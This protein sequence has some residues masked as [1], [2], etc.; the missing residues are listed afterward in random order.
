MF[1]S[2]LQFGHTVFP[3]THL[4]IVANCS[5]VNGCS[6]LSSS[7]LSKIKTI[8]LCN[9]IK[10]LTNFPRPGCLLGDFLASYFFSFSPLDAVCNLL[11]TLHPLMAHLNTVLYQGRLP[12]RFAYEFPL[13]SQ[14]IQGCND[15][16]SNPN[17][18]RRR[19]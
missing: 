11:S 18:T 5:V 4:Q 10:E 14:R 8:K 16:R 15:I 3:S 12:F 13:Q 1:K 9:P 17:Y 2:V 19:H 6:S 7:N